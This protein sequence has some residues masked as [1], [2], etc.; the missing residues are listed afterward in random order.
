MP[1][2]GRSIST[3]EPFREDLILDPWF[4]LPLSFDS[5]QTVNGTSLSYSRSLLR[6][7]IG[8]DICEPKEAPAKRAA[9]GSGTQRT[10]FGRQYLPTATISTTKTTAMG[11]RV[12]R[13]L[14]N[15]NGL[16][17]LGLRERTSRREG[18]PGQ[19]ICD[20]VWPNADASRI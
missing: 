6:R 19:T 3:T 13:T 7:I 1:R 20:N 11:I 9:T 8:V 10:V 17:E 15:S 14:S 2:L 12:R 18:D 4:R 16:G 5:C